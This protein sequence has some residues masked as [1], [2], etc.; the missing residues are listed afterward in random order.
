MLADHTL[1]LWHANFGA[2]SLNDINIWDWLPLY[3][4]FING[5][6]VE[7]VDF[8]F[9]NG[10]ERFSKLWATANGIYPD[11]EHLAKSFSELMG[12]DNI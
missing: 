8:E 4:S 9:E 5:T 1:W 10:G 11:L 6:F 7:N 3:E 2:G 12:Q